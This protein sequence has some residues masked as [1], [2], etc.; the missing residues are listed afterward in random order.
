MAARC[1]LSEC[2]AN[3]DGSSKHSVSQTLDGAHVQAALI[4]EQVAKAKDCGDIDSAVGLAAT[5]K[6]LLA[7]IDHTEKLKA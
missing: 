7:V 6:R 2:A 4:Q 3:I 1:L 5:A